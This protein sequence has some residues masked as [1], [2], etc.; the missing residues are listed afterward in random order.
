MIENSLAFRK[1]FACGTRECGGITGTIRKGAVQRILQRGR[2]IL[3]Q[4][5]GLLQKRK[6]RGLRA[7][8]QVIRTQ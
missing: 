6:V 5:R 2:R 8:S 4:I 1:T 3:Q 7:E